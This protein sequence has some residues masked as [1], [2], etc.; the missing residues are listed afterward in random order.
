[1][2]GVKGGMA[3]SQQQVKDAVEAGY[4]HL[5]RFDPRLKAQGK[6]PFQ[7]DSKPPTKSYTEFLKSENRFTALERSFP[8]RAAEL[9]ALSGKIAAEKYKRL[10]KLGELYK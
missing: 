5:F 10:E 8:E 3:N 2:H 7:L 4:W 9:F 6:P 1:M